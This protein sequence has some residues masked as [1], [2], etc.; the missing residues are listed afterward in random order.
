M[1]VVHLFADDRLEQS[2]GTTQE[3]SYKDSLY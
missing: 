3:A 1:I 2:Y